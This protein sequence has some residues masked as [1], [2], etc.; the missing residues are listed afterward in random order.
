[1]DIVD[2]LCPVLPQDTIYLHAEEGLILRRGDQRILVKGKSIAEQFGRIA[3]LLDGERTLAEA[4]GM[5]CEDEAGRSAIGKLLLQL[6]DRRF[7]LQRSAADRSTLPASERARWRDVIA[8]LGHYV[9]NPVTAFRNFRKA[10]VLLI[11]Q[12][13][14]H[15]SFVRALALNGLRELQVGRTESAT[16]QADVDDVASAM[17]VIGAGDLLSVRSVVAP[18]DFSLFDVVCYAADAPDLNA[19]GQL[20]RS[21]R[22]LGT[23]LF[24]GTVLGEA[25]RLGPLDVRGNPCWHC[26]LLRLGDS[27]PPK[28][29]ELLWRRLARRDNPFRGFSGP[30]SP[31]SM[32]IAGNALALRVFRFLSGISRAEGDRDDHIESVSSLTLESRSAV[33]LPHPACDCWRET[34]L[35]RRAGDTGGSPT[36][37]MAQRALFDPEVGVFAEFDDDLLSQVPVFSSCVKMHCRLPCGLRRLATG[38]SLLS[39]EHAR[40][41]ALLHAAWWYVR[42]L[43]ERDG[44]G[45]IPDAFAL[46]EDRRH[47]DVHGSL[48]A[49]EGAIAREAASTLAVHL[50]PGGRRLRVAAGE[51]L[52]LDPRGGFVSDQWWAGIACGR[53]AAQARARARASLVGGLAARAVARGTL[54]F[55][56]VD[57]WS[58]PL[59]P[60]VDLLRSI[61]P[62][63]IVGVAGI[64]G[65]WVACAPGNEDAQAVMAASV[66][67]EECL[68]QCLADAIAVRAGDASERTFRTWLPDLHE[69][70]GRQPTVFTGPVAETTLAAFVQPGASIAMSIGLVALT[71]A[72]LRLAGLHVW[73]AVCL[74]RA[75]R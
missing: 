53:S 26:M 7:L 72:D 5:G 1:M 54:G 16:E 12:G 48:P 24:T 19:V 38:H 14:L 11:G 44:W 71:P 69:F 46:P 41:D 59:A 9:D 18:L 62:Q 4:I 8:F 31:P 29:A 43:Y 49:G 25:P 63:A 40:E 47:Y 6:V 65:L 13:C 64:D 37:A 27:L 73:K 57:T 21:C 68:A 58:A 28:E 34:G 20:S 15:R 74:T 66:A 56:Q 22:E 42:G 61:D 3:P 33:L 35:R 75:R 30:S 32:R 70:D 39:N 10:R 52:P 17:A 60:H 45:L 67:R 51:L 50:E 23:P 2:T 36:P 55:A